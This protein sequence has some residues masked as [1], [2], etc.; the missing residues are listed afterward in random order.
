MSWAVHKKSHLIWFQVDELDVSSFFLSSLS[1]YVN[2]LRVSSGFL[3]FSF[4][5]L[6]FSF[7]LTLISV[8][9]LCVK[10]WD[11]WDR[12]RDISPLLINL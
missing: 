9:N 2:N 4:S 6:S 11:L 5:T 8:S 1:K 12:V 7:S 3:F 10:K